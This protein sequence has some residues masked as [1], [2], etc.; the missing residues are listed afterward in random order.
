[1]KNPNLSFG[2]PYPTRGKIYEKNK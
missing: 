1:M 2:K